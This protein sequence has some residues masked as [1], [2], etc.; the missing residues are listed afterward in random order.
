MKPDYMD[1]AEELANRNVSLCRALK[2]GFVTWG[3][4]GEKTL[5]FVSQA[6]G[7][8]AAVDCT[9]QKSL[10]KKFEIGGFPTRK[11]S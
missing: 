3:I 9:K 10:A 5:I 8:L 1:A 11:Y 6:R 4:E 7:V 2:F